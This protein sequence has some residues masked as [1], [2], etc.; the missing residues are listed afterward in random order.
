MIRKLRGFRHE[1]DV[2]EEVNNFLSAA[3]VA[4]TDRGSAHSSG[5]MWDLI[6]NVK[7]RPLLI[8]SIGLQMSQQLCG[9][10]AVFYYSTAF[11]TD[12]ISN[13]LLGTCLVNV[14]NVLATFVAMKL[15][16]NTNRRTLLLWSSAGM[17]LACLLLTASALGYT[18]KSIALISFI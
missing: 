1:C 13:P 3:S 11:F 10:N 12:L 7:Y 9:I 5:A 17:L 18:H 14:V 2:D 4:K 8:A 16:D 15:M 6:K